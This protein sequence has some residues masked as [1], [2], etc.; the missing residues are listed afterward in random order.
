MEIQ[1]E[2]MIMK[3]RSPGSLGSTQVLQPVK[4]EKVKKNI[5]YAQKYGGQD[6]TDSDSSKDLV[7]GDR[8]ITNQNED[9]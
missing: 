1:L 2:A 6:E 8:T 7:E 3:D 5:K 9:Y 4:R